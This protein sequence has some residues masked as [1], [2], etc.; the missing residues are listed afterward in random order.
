MPLLT[1]EQQL[2]TDEQARVAKILSIDETWAAKHFDEWFEVFTVF[3]HLDMQLQWATYILTLDPEKAWKYKSYA[4]PSE[5]R[6]ERSQ[7]INSLRNTLDE[8]VKWFPK[9]DQPF[10][11]YQELAKEYAITLPED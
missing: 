6:K 5:Y 1:E 2:P 4:S 8:Y 10:S 11:Y 3:E 7:V 9:E